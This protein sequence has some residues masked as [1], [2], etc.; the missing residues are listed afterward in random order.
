MPTTRVAKSATAIRYTLVR[1][2]TAKR[3]SN[4]PRVR[5]MMAASMEW[6]LGKLG[7]VTATRWGTISGRSRP[8]SCFITVLST[9]PPRYRY[10]PH[11]PIFPLERQISRG[12]HRHGTQ[13][14]AAT[15]HGDVLVD[16][17]QP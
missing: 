10:Q 2:R 12:K 3:A 8:N 14:G 6:P 13:H 15:E 9:P 17:H 1:R 4:A 11:R 7:E 5:Y 16:R